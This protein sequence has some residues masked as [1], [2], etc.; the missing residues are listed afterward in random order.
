MQF[1]ATLH[2]GDP[3]FEVNVTNK[4]F[5]QSWPRPKNCGLHRRADSWCHH[6]WLFQTSI[7]WSVPKLRNTEK[8]M[9]KVSVRNYLP[10]KIFPNKIERNDKKTKPLSF[11]KRHFAPRISN[12]PNI[13]WIVFI[14]RWN[15]WLISSFPRKLMQVYEETFDITI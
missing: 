13:I 6:H 12:V 3:H 4:A 10:F 5:L 2:N 7:A 14:L 9:E 1:T 11:F 8:Q 15:S